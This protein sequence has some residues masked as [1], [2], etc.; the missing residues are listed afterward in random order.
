MY[1]ADRQKSKEARAA[2]EQ[3][4]ALLRSQ[5]DSSLQRMS[6]LNS[7]IAASVQ[8]EAKLKADIEAAVASA[9]ADAAAARQTYEDESAKLRAEISAHPAPKEKCV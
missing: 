9:A 3:E 8:R 7:E 1:I 4:I 2:A 6:S 5:A